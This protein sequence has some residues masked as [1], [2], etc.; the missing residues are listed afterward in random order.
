MLFYLYF[1]CI[2]SVH[3][4]ENEFSTFD[5]HYL[6]CFRFA[7]DIDL[8]APKVRVPIGT[9]GSSKCDSH[10]LLDFGHFTLHTKVCLFFLCDF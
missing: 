1:V 5:L 10:F 9:C 3:S 4:K 2:H 7:L 8:D 6:S